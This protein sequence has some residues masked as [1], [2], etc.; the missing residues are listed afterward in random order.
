MRY[1][2]WAR[3]RTGRLLVILIA[4][5]LYVLLLI[6]DGLHFF[7]PTT[8]VS[9]LD[10]AR[11]GFSAFIA[12]LYLAV[13]ALV[14]LF[15]RD[16]RVAFLL[17]CFS[18]TMMVVF[19]VE[20]AAVQTNDARIQTITDISSSLT[21]ILFS[22]LLLIFPKNY[23]ASHKQPATASGPIFQSGL[24]YDNSLLLR[25]YVAVLVL[26]SIISMLYSFLKDS[27]ILH[28]PDWLN[29]I[30]NI[31]NLLALVGILATITIS[32]RQASS[33][34]V[35]QQRRFFVIG[36]IL[37]FAPFLFLTLLPQLFLPPRFMINAQVS[38]LT[39]VLLPLALGYSILRYQIL[40]FDTY[41]RRAVAWI[42]GG[43]SLAVAGYLVV[44]LCRLL[45]SGN[46]TAWTISVVVALLILGPF[47]WWLAHVV[48][49]RLFFSEIVHYRRLV[50]SPVLLTRETFDL[51]EASELLAIAVVNAF[52][53]QEVCLFVLDEDTGYYRLSPALKEDDPDDASRERLV[54]HLLR[55]GGSATNGNAQLPQHADWL[56]VQ[57]PIIE[58]IAHA[59]RPL[60]LSE[61]SK[62]GA[63]QP[64]GLA[65]YLATTISDR[66][67][68]LLAPVRA[69]GKMIG[70]LVLG[71][72]A[73]HEPFA[74]PD[75]EVIDL[76]TTRFAPVL[77]T[78]RLYEQASQHVAT[79][80]T[81]Y[82]ASATLEKAYQSIEE[83]ASAYAMVAAGAVTAGAEVWLYDEAD[84]TLRHVTHLGSGPRL[85][86]LESLTSLQEYDW[87]AR[88]YDGN[89][90]QSGKSPPA[91]VPPCLAQ[92]PSF[93]FAWIPLAK[94]QQHYGILVLT[95]QRPHIF[96]QEEQ[97]V[98]G[99]FANQCAA[100]M[101]NARIT[102][103]LR[104]AYERQKEL[105]RLK[106]QFIMTAS[107]ELRTPLTAVQGYID[108][109]DHY[110]AS[111]STEERAD[112]IAKAQRGSDELA[113]MLSNIMDVSRV[114][115]DVEQVKLSKVSLAN[116]V[117][118]ILEILEA[119]TRQEKR[120]IHVDMP[121]QIPVLAD[122][123]R[124]RQ[125][126]L[127]LVG[128]ALKYSPAGTRIDIT[129]GVHGEEVTF[130]VRDFGLGVSPGDQGRLFQ[131]FVRLER[132]MNSPVRGAGLGLYISKRLIE[133][134]GGRIWVE[135]S[136]RP[137][138][139][140]IFAFTL[141]CVVVG[142]EIGTGLQTLPHAN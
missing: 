136:G 56:G 85:T 32:Y 51:D 11:F 64:A 131:R 80:D 83:V 30:V 16:R 60:L 74:G 93:P 127:N 58:N 86:P 109:L 21:L 107:H 19:A 103:A 140:S 33:L 34:R 68:P 61:A 14:W 104:S 128:N 8:S 102:I 82:S 76:I 108:L 81:L 120:D 36:V 69:Q 31:Y 118:H 105:D 90:A 123:L 25:V 18:F 73:D 59:R 27:F 28:L 75:F 38:T 37:A 57:G 92:T 77:E 20:T 23:L 55:V 97:R 43:V 78:A 124:L 110:N 137:G 114:D 4:V 29:S 6:V 52:E 2:S 101:E 48:T 45:W 26:L 84:R 9:P 3:I 66:P 112:F 63:E 13:G 88:F 71:E 95:Y 87:T 22:I 119:I 46:A 126:L 98:L 141:K 42:A 39:A 12:I 134:M 138:D 142:E 35:R 70:I 50:D 115:A 135:S 65:R 44:M 133:A 94:G 41:I 15:A 91:D 130:C 54:Q 53:T 139:G 96:S 111:L 89:S 72:R 1:G 116:S 47:V 79:L 10:W 99:M 7:S 129:A 49:E 100:V 40:V 5:V 122:E 62:A 17:F 125:V 113:L 117:Q 132:D 67:D 106:D 24:R 121:A